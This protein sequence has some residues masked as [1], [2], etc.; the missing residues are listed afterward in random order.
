MILEAFLSN[1]ETLENR[2]ATNAVQ[3]IT[4]IKENISKE[5]LRSY[6]ASDTPSK[7][8]RSFNSLT[9]LLYIRYYHLFLH[10]IKFALKDIK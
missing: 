6:N 10:I 8:T 9:K 4:R 7:L 2:S 3:R 1:F 5:T